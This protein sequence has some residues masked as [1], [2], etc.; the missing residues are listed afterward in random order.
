MAY[1]GLRKIIIAERT[2]AKTYGEQFAFGKAIGLNVTPNYSE[3]SLN[4]D[5]VQAEYDKEFNYAEVTMNTSTVPLVAHDKMFGHK[6]NENA[7]DFNAY[8]EANYVGQAWIAPEKVD[9]KKYYTGNFLYKAKYSEPS[10]E[11]S[12]KGD[13][14][15]YKTPSISGR[16]LAEDDGDWKATER[17]ETPEKALEWIYKKFGKSAVPQKVLKNQEAAVTKE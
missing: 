11:Y 6:V 8:D 2:G 12:T 1:V 10:E 7:V 13:S 4:A 15:E 17:F 5:D 16:A 14:I 3:G 9:G